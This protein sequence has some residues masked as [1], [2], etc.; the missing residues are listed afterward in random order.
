[1]YKLKLSWKQ[2]NDIQTEFQTNWEPAKYS[3]TQ[4]AREKRFECLNT[5]KQYKKG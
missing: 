4:Q 2:K 5:D 1:M 3:D